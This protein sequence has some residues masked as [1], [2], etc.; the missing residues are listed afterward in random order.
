MMR[1]CFS[2][3]K[4]IGIVFA[5]SLPIIIAELWT[6]MRGLISPLLMPVIVVLSITSIVIPLVIMALRPKFCAFIGDYVELSTYLCRER[7]RIIEVI[8][9]K[10]SL[11]DYSVVVPMGYRLYP[12]ING[13]G[14]SSNVPGGDV[15]VFSTGNCDSGWKLLKLVD[16][17]GREFYAIICCGS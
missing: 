2:P 16:G 10:G 15:L 11:R 5:A 7:F 17:D 9:E 6:V 4:V 14:Y 12:S 1:I 3:F 13:W 8:D